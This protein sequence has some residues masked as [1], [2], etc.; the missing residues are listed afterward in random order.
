[1][2]QTIKYKLPKPVNFD[3]SNPEFDVF[4]KLPEENCFAPEIKFLRKI[5]IATNSVIFSYFKVFRDSCLGEE[6]YQKYRSWRFF[7]KFIFPKFNFSKKRFLLITD[8]YCSNYFHW[9][10]FA[11]K[12]LLVLQKHGL[13]KDSILLLP[14][15]Y[16]KYPFVFP[17]LAKF[18]ITKQQIVFLPRKSNIKVAEIPFVKDPYHHPQIS[19][20]LRG[21][22]TGN[23]LSL[24]LGEK[25]YIS[26]EKQILR[27]VENED[28]VMKLL[29]KYGFKKIIA[30][31]F[32]YEEQIAIFSRT[33]YLIGPHGAGL[34]NV[35]FMKEG[36]AILELAGKNNGFNRDYLA[37][38]SMIGVRY[39]YQQ[40]PHGEKGIKKDFHHG[41]LMIDIKKLEKN[42]QLMLQ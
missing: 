36:S 25:I 4:T 40:C 33:K 34:T 14:K 41:S 28:E 35:L 6:Q 2:F 30:E 24:D 22:L 16:Q 37:L 19:R 12:R 9:H 7:F 10:V 20:Q 42:L 1:M 15:K 3:E 8:E 26:R 32:S 27:F 21:I 5:R 31:Q 18:G 38:S 11:L 29:T 13:I 39:F 17:S 23:T